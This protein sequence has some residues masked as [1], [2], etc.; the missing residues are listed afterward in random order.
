MRLIGNLLVWICLAIGLIAATSFYAWPVGADASVDARFELGRGD[1]GAPR[2]V[3]VL[4]DVKSR[5][6][7]VVVRADSALD[8]AT[9][10]I[11]REA[12]AKR[13]MIKHPS[14]AAGAIVGNWSG[15]WIFL[16]AVGGLVAGAFFIRSSVRKSVE[17]TGGVHFTARPEDLVLRLRDEVSVLRARLPGLLDDM[18]RL[19]AIIEQLG[20]V[21]AV[22]VPTFVETR[23]LLVAQRGVG[24]FARVMD[25][26]ATA[27]RKINRA[28]SAAADG[29]LHESLTALDDAA[30]ACDQLVQGV[31]PGEA[32][33]A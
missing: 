21:Q 23:P 28:W 10:A 6:G 33:K 3:E 9:L 19:R 32:T 17:Q 4:R 22:L 13:V 12:G 26:F 27:E 18:A 15:K 31:S 30:L 8:P 16:L 20:E 7:Q 25:L 14:G 29:V 11:V 5:D 1:D 2:Y 24:G